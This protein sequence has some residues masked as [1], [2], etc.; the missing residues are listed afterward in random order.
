MDLTK[1]SL[2]TKQIATARAVL[3]YQPFIITDSLQT[4]VAYS[5]LYGDQGGRTSHG[6]RFRLR[7]QHSN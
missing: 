2:S 3:D 5:W 6:L 1:Y 4:G 7:S